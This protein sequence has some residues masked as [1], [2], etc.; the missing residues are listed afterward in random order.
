MEMGVPMN[1][2]ATVKGGLKE[3]QLSQRTAKKLVTRMGTSVALQLMKV[4]WMRRSRSRASYG[5]LWQL[6]GCLRATYVTFI[7]KLF[8]TLK[9]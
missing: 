7:T 3:S 4:Q 8:L 5:D 9:R 2:V 1:I 6:A